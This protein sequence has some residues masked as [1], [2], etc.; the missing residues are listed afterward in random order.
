MEA[1]VKVAKN[2]LG[3]PRA[4]EEGKRWREEPEAVGRAISDRQREPRLGEPTAGEGRM[5]RRSKS[6]KQRV[7]WHW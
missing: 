2:R 7:G 1:E 5:A 3:E 4:A 6:G